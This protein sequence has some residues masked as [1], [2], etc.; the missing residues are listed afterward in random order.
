[1]I[2]QLMTLTITPWYVAFISKKLNVACQLTMI[3]GSADNA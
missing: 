3:F 2:I 1:M